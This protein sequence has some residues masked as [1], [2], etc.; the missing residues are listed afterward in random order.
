LTTGEAAANA[1]LTLLAQVMATK[2][3]RSP[4]LGAANCVAKGYAGNAT[5][6]T[7]ENKT[8]KQMLHKFTFSFQPKLGTGFLLT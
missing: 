8:S 2:P 1:L 7:A 3:L 6:H 5:Q 4:F